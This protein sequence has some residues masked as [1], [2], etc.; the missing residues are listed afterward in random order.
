VENS[1]AFNKL[2]ELTDRL[3]SSGDFNAYSKPR[4]LLVRE[5]AAVSGAGAAPGSPPQQQSSA[6]R[7]VSQ[8]EAASRQGAGPGRN[9]GE[10]GK[11][12]EGHRSTSSTAADVAG[13]TEGQPAATDADKPQSDAAAAAPAQ[14]LRDD[15]D[16]FGDDFSTAA[17]AE[18]RGSSRPKA[19]LPPVWSGASEVPGAAAA[20]S[21]ATDAARPA[22][23]SAVDNNS[24]AT[25]M[26][27]E[28][29][30]VTDS[31]TAGQPGAASTT[32]AVGPKAGARE[33]GT[34]GGGSDADVL[35]GFELDSSTGLLYSTTLGRWWC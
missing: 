22:A 3:L 30:P 10:E 4:E 27:T 21:G 18:L 19:A 7:A 13:T 1:V 29:T 5:A 2:A 24:G 32:A 28:Q 25:A 15:E 17:Y 16:M 14:V 26:E 6:A 11:G 20:A 23:T 9:A 35:T 33:G 8:Q 12:H 34:E 31:A